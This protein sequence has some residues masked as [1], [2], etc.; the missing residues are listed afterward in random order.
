[1]KKRYKRWKDI[2]N[3]AELKFLVKLHHPNI[4][5]IIEIMKYKNELNIAFE[6][7]KK[8]LY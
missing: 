1:M 6:Y 7:L 8:N 2:I 5:D 3:L 4:V